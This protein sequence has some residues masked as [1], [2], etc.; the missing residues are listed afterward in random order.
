MGRL[1]FSLGKFA[2]TALCS[3]SPR[4]SHPHPGC[5]APGAV[6]GAVLSFPLWLVLPVPTSG[7]SLRENPHFKKADLGTRRPQSGPGWLGNLGG[8]R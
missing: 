2:G 3:A 4:T 7:P 8:G 5:L 1:R 6:T